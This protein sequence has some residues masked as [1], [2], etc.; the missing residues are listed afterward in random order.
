MVI[1]TQDS[2]SK[3]HLL[4][5]HT[6]VSYCFK[7]HSLRNKSTI[8]YSQ[9]Q[10]LKCKLPNKKT[11]GLQKLTAMLCSLFFQMYMLKNIP[12]YIT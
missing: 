3:V 12:K 9:V 4:Q 11:L 1:A 5:I 10:H 6:R 2:V 7:K 8:Q